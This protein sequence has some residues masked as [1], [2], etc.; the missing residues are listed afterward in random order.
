MKVPVMLPGFV[1]ADGMTIKK[2]KL[3]GHE[4]LGMLASERELGLV[5]E[6]AGIIEGDAGWTVGAA[7]AQYIALDDTTYDVEITPNR[8][9]SC[10]TSAWP[11]TS[12]KFRIPWHWPEYALSEIAT[13]ALQ[14]IGVRI[15]APEG[16]PRYAARLVR[17]ITVASSPYALRLRLMRCGIRPI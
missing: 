3:K 12:P 9:I 6:H 14:T 7:A 11:A 5:E 4:S 16:C 13:P 8:R 17:G 10:R 15:D 1:T 2:A